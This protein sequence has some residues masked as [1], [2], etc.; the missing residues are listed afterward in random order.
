MLESGQIAPCMSCGHLPARAG[1]FL[2]GQLQVALLREGALNR[3]VI[4]LPH[5]H[6][7][8]IRL[9]AKSMTAYASQLATMPHETSALAPP[10]LWLPCTVQASCIMQAV[11]TCT[12]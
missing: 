5:M 6:K 2:K 8:S 7:C 10:L 3:F 12:V 1:V 9:R 11:S 4:Y